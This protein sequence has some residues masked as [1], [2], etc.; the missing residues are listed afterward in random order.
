MVRRSPSHFVKIRCDNQNFFVFCSLR[1]HQ[2]SIYTTLSSEIIGLQNEIWKGI[3]PFPFGFFS[4]Q[5]S[6]AKLSSF[7][8]FFPSSFTGKIVPRHP[9]RKCTFVIRYLK[10]SQRKNPE[11][12]RTTSV[13]KESSLFSARI[14][15]AR[16][17]K[18]NKHLCTIL[19]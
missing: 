17:L 14:N 4:L 12:T 1:L 19:R 11:R 3:K 8:I 15:T 5:V 18:N 13:P 6:R 2:I 7:R 16:R 10:L 9:A